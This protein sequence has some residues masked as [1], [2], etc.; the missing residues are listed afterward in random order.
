M[1]VL[2]MNAMKMSFMRSSSADSRRHFAPRIFRRQWK[3]SNIS[4]SF[5][6]HVN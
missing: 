6:L 1:S 4:F 2:D 5:C 3:L